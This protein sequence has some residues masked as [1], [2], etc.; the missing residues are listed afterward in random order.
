MLLQ[1]DR[2]LH[3]DAGRRREHASEAPEA[4][5]T[6]VLS[7]TNERMRPPGGPPVACRS[8]EAADGT[9]T[10]VTIE[11]VVRRRDERVT[12]VS[13]EQQT[14]L[15]HIISYILFLL[16]P[17]AFRADLALPLLLRVG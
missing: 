10:S 6:L 15:W 1:R 16:N 11:M 3:L 8:A 12:A 9:A 2:F 17:V 13:D 14:S 5:Q 4:D 7:A